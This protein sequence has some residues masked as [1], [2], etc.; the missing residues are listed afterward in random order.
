MATHYGTADVLVQ[1]NESRSKA[2]RSTLAA[3]CW[4][5]RSLVDMV[6]AM[7]SQAAASRAMHLDHCTYGKRFVVES[8]TS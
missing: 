5:L 8:E 1:S 7:L 6:S 2:G 3:R 4:E